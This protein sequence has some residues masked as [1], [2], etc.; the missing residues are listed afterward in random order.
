MRDACQPSRALTQLLRDV[1]RTPLLTREE[2]HE[3]A[4]RVSENNDEIAMQAL[5]RANLRFVVKVA[6]TFRGYGLPLADLVQE[7]ALGLM[8]AVRK[9]EPGRGFRLISYA[10]WW[11]RAFM[12]NYVMHAHSLVK[13]GTTQAQRKLFFKLRAARERSEKR[14]DAAD[15]S[16]VIGDI[17]ESLGVKESEVRSMGARMAG[18]DVSLDAPLAADSTN[19]RLDLVEEGADGPESQ[20]E[21][22]EMRAL[23]QRRVA[24]VLP[25]LNVKERYIVANRLL[26]DEP[27]TLQAVGEF[28]RISRERARQ[29]ESVVLRKMRHVLSD[30]EGGRAP[31]RT[32]NISERQAMQAA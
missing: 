16:R 32:L 18:H 23:V 15:F 14:G 29:I 27:I 2:E 28:F 4:L 31:W 17:A 6:Y 10:V 5:V 20:L 9:F 21:G 11:V 7:G 30:F 3:L 26:C 12:Q 24:D 13:L 1:R 25:K 22:D 19:T 8:A